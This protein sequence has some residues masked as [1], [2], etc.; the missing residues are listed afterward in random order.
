[1]VATQFSSTIKSLQ[2]DWGGEFQ[3]VSSLLRSH[4]IQHRVSC[5]YT[6]EQNGAVERQNRVIVEKGLALFAHSSLPHTFWEHAFKTATYL[7][8]WTTTP[9]LQHNS[10]YQQL[11]QTPPDYSFLKTFGCLCYP[12]LRPYNTHKTDFRSK[13]CVF[14]GYSSSHKGYMCYDKMTSR[15]YISRHVVFDETTFPF[16]SPTTITTPTLTPTTQQHPDAIRYLQHAT[17]CATTNIPSLHQMSY[18]DPNSL[19]ST[20]PTSQLT[21]LTNPSPTNPIRQ[22]SPS[23]SY[24]HPTISSQ[25]KSTQPSTSHYRPASHSI[26]PMTTRASTQ[27]IKP[28]IFNVTTITNPKLD[29]PVTFNQANKHIWWQTAMHDEYNALM[30]NNTWSLVACPT[31]VNLVGCKWI[32][33]VK[34]NSEK[35]VQRHK[36][37]LVAQ[38]FSQEAGVDVFDTFSPVIKPTTIRL[39]LS[40]ALSQKWSIR[41]LDINNAFLNGDLTE[42]V[43]MK[44]PR[45]FEDPSRPDHVCKL[46]KALYG[47]RQA[48]RA[49]FTK[50]K[51]YLLGQGFRACHS[52]T[53]LLVYISSTTTIYILVYVDDLIITDGGLQLSQQQYIKG[54]LNSCNMV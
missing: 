19:S 2:T 51:T 52:D 34:R 39:V 15:L 22:P 23:P 48:P 50:L 16:A 45:G 21:P 27:S 47:L 8:N 24:H 26:H 36:A 37:R 5:P 35:T 14:L 53:S 46:H 9:T 25:A 49:W 32:Y 31:N 10:P 20:P 11:Y 30:R 3:N 28:K 38:G 44:Q 33:R 29:E 13:P 4:G 6:Q 43:Y 41:Q 40:I 1:M 17:T 18:P 7:H 54:I 12:F 42:E